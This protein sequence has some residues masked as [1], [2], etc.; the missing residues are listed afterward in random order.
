[1]KREYVVEQIDTNGDV[2][3]IFNKERNG[4]ISRMSPTENG[5]KYVSKFLSRENVEKFAKTVQQQ[6]PNVNI[7]VSELFGFV[8][9]STK[10]HVAPK[11]SKV[12]DKSPYKTI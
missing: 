10:T 1:M 3:S 2:V 5:Y 9:V 8:V 6:R 7:R 12:N 4:Q 11:Q